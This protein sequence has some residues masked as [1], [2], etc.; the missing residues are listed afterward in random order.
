MHTA[1]LWLLSIFQQHGPQEVSC[2]QIAA[3]A[4]GTGA[5]HI[6]KY[7]TWPNT[8]HE[9]SWPQLHSSSAYMVG[10]TDRA[11]PG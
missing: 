7:M 10:C 8:V 3:T 6:P 4:V 5:Q 11:N 1:I 9:G 2:S